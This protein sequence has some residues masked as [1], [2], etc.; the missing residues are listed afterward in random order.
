M[1]TEP[2]APCP[3]VP[4]KPKGTG[5]PEG[6]GGFACRNSPCPPP[7]PL[8]T[9]Q[10][11]VTTGTPPASAQQL[12]PLA[13]LVNCRP[14]K[15]P[16]GLWSTT[17]NSW[18]SARLLEPKSHECM[19]EKSDPSCTR[20]P[21]F[22]P[23]TLN[24]DGSER[25][26]GRPSARQLEAGGEV[27]SRANEMQLARRSHQWGRSPRKPHGRPR[28][29]NR[30]YRPAHGELEPGPSGQID[31]GEASAQLLEPAPQRERRPIGGSRHTRLPG[32]WTVPLMPR[33]PIPQSC[34]AP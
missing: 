29:R 11:P 13:Y 19:R 10:L 25:P 3:R 31:G 14:V 20:R 17:Q 27:D 28:A 21:T 33:P 4:F 1:T 24:R 15:V 16:P 5:D 18:A 12:E 22:G 23:H 7:R 8:R 34:W 2:H 30:V 9:H 32:P 6:H 26:G